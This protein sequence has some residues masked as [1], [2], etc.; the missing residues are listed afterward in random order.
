MLMRKEAKNIIMIVKQKEESNVVNRKKLKK[1]TGIWIL[2][3]KG[4]PM[5]F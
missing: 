4:A 1:K 2:N 3:F 5:N